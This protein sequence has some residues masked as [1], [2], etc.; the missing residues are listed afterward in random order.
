MILQALNFQDQF[1]RNKD[2]IRNWTAVERQFFFTTEQ[3][4][5]FWKIKEFTAKFTK[6]SGTNRDLC[7]GFQEQP[8]GGLV[9][10]V[11]DETS[12]AQ[13]EFYLPH[14]A[15]ISKMLKVESYELYM[16]DPKGKTAKVYH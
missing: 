4:V 13:G 11:N 9:E 10:K 3:M 15:V 7:P 16:M 5:Q 12:Y 6:K 2:V 14:K 8:T 1:R